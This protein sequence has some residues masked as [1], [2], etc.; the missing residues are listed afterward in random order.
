MKQEQGELSW[1][2]GWHIEPMADEL[3]ND[4]WRALGEVPVCQNYIVRVSDIIRKML[5]PRAYVTCKVWNDIVFIVNKLLDW[6]VTYCVQWLC[7]IVCNDTSMSDKPNACLFLS[8]AIALCV[9]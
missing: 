4:S 8:P 7:I 6:W 3:L 2:L 9:E 1:L 5:S